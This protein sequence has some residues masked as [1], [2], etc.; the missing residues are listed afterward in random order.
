MRPVF[1]YRI[2]PRQQHEKLPLLLHASPYHHNKD[3]ILFQLNHKNT[4]IILAPEEVRELSSSMRLPVTSVT[5]RFFDFSEEEIN[6]F[7]EHFNL[8]F[9]KGGG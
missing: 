7:I 9:M 4:E 1:I 3:T 8:T 5:I 6:G 2:S